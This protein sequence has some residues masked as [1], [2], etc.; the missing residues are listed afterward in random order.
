MKARQTELEQVTDWPERARQAG[1]RVSELA[2]LCGVSTRT[3]DRFFRRHL[4]VTPRQWMHQMRRSEAARFAREGRTAK[5][6]AR[7]IGYN[8]APSY[9]RAKKS[10]LGE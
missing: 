6:I 2:A 8:H 5:E 7:L 10:S 3:L 4:K 9:H 1:Y